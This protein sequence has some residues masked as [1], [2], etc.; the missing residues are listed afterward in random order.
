MQLHSS[1]TLKKRLHLFRLR[2]YKNFLWKMRSVSLLLLFPAASMCD[3]GFL[4]MKQ[5]KLRK[6]TGLS[7][8]MSVLLS[9]R[10]VKWT[11]YEDSQ[12]PTF[13]LFKYINVYNEQY[14]LFG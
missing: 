11:N 8:N 5:F 10:V 2:L 7:V 14:Y 12:A 6:G 3:L 9:T 1:F 4:T 13:D